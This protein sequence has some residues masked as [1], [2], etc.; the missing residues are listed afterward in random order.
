M[1]A[2]PWPISCPVHGN[3]GGDGDD[4]DDSDDG[5]D[6]V[7]GD[8]DWPMARCS[9]NALAQSWLQLLLL[10]C[11]PVEGEVFQSSVCV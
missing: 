1:M 8:F 10:V 6:C 4:G 5:D 3:D 11:Q 7:D 2:W 9:P